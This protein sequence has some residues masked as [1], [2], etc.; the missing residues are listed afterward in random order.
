MKR[1]QIATDFLIA[2]VIIAFLFALL[3]K[4]Y[5]DQFAFRLSSAEE[6]SALRIAESVGSAANFA[7]SEGNGSS[8]RVFLEPLSSG[9]NYSV[10]F[11]QRR[12]EVTWP[13]SPANKSVSYP[14]LSPS[15]SSGI[16]YSGE[17]IRIANDG[18]VLRVS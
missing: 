9:S 3:Y 1:G 8:A 12:V 2:C 14:I 17:T 11:L 13:V 7:L 5:S 4:L 15:I 16:H 6:Q 18:G 10:F